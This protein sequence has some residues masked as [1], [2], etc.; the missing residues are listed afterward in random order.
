MTAMSFFRSG[1]KV[2][3]WCLHMLL[4][5]PFKTPWV[6]WHSRYREKIKLYIWRE[7]IIRKKSLWHGVENVGIFRDIFL[8]VFE[9]EISGFKW[10]TPQRLR[11]NKVIL[12]GKGKDIKNHFGMV[13]K[14]ALENWGHLERDIFVFVFEVDF[15]GFKC[16]RPQKAEVNK[17]WRKPLWRQRTH[18]KQAACRKA[19]QIFDTSPESQKSGPKC[20]KSWKLRKHVSYLLYQRYFPHFVSQESQAGH[21]FDHELLNVCK[22]WL[23]LR[24]FISQWKYQGII[25]EKTETPGS[26]FDLWKNVLHWQNFFLPTHQETFPRTSFQEELKWQRR[27]NPFL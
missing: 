14:T 9:V 15:S 1:W 20:G 12:E 10:Q 11:E 23:P 19:F 4:L 16:H 7:R 2:P 24:Q 5:I 25:A 27:Q 26:K 17:R 21:Y 8:F 22:I 18:W 3:L 13:W 6:V